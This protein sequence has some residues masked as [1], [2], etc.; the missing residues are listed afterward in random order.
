MKTI[1]NAVIRSILAI[2]IGFALMAQAQPSPGRGSVRIP[3]STHNLLLEAKVSGNLESYEKTPLK[4]IHF[5]GEKDLSWL[6][7]RLAPIAALNTMKDQPTK[8]VGV[9]GKH[10]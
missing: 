10:L 8:L 7:A 4:S 1:P 5:R 9:G 3:E 6:V 2:G